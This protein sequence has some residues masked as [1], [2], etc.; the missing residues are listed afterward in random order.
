[1]YMEV[2]F[3]YNIT[4]KFIIGMITGAV[5]V[6]ALYWLWNGGFLMELRG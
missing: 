2:G 5:I 1:M 3:I 4:L 6:Y